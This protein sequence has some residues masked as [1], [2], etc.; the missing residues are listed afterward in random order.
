MDRRQA[1]APE[2]LGQAERI[3]AGGE[4]D[5]D[6]E[7]GIAVPLGFAALI[8]HQ[9]VALGLDGGLAFGKRLVR[10]LPILGNRMPA[11][12]LDVGAPL[13]VLLVKSEDEPARAFGLL[14]RARVEKDPRV[15][16][17]D[18]HPIVEGLAEIVLE[19][20]RLESLD[21]LGQMPGIVKVDLKPPVIVH[22]GPTQYGVR[23]RPERA[24]ELLAAERGEIEK[25]IAAAQR[26]GPLEG[27]ERMEPGDE[28][29]EDLYQDEF[30]AG[31][32][33]DLQQRLAAVERAE[34]R[35][36]A[37]TYGLSVRSGEPIPDE[38]LEASP[39]AELTVEESEHAA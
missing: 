3:V 16:A 28:G 15:V 23:V 12:Q 5:P 22:A 1:L 32:L 36:A 13:L 34:E 2:P 39:T 17:A 9:L 11:L 25:E 26:G 8:R 38:R 10:V 27:N 35:L 21:Q 37:G 4:V 30:D 14:P 19:L 24:R 31:R 20:T 6:L 29:S 33:D 7:F 18:D